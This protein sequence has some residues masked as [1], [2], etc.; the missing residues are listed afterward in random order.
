MLALQDAST[1]QI[2]PEI[3]PS[4][5]LLAVLHP[6]SRILPIAGQEVL[7]AESVLRM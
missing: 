2:S 3:L 1:R 5:C 4:V 7:C 6:E